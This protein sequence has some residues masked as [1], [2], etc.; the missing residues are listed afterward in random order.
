MRRSLLCA[1]AAC[2]APRLVALW[3]W[4]HPAHTYQWELSESLL[5]HGVFGFDGRSTTYLEPLYPAVLAGL[6]LVAGDRTAIVLLLQIALAAAAGP[7][8]FLLALRIGGRRAAWIA[9]FA[10]ASY[11]YLVRQS[12]AY[13]ALNLTVPLALGAALQMSRARRPAR[14]VSAGVWMGTLM[15]ARASFGLTTVAAAGWVAWRRRPALGALLLASALAIQTPW[16]VRN[17]RVGGVLLPTRVG[18]NLL[19]STSAYA[20]KVV[21][22]YDVDALIPLVYEETAAAVPPDSLDT[23]RAISRA[24]LAR[25]LRF[26]RDHPVRTLRLKLRNAVALL[27]PRLLPR[28]PTGPEARAVLSDG[29]LQLEGL[30]SRPMVQEIGQAAAR[31]TILALVGVAFWERRRWTERD[32]AI[33]LV[34]ATNAILC[35]VFF[36]STRLIVPSTAMLMIYAGVGAVSLRRR[37]E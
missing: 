31:A 19:V 4:P 27:D 30:R 35:V 32:E 9:V 10:Y 6:R 11:P 21:P 12:V 22:I 29:R 8:L 2:V 18:E 13:M 7:L 16:L 3:R 17:V 28:W 15:L 14:A 37:F 36:P 34:A 5:R 20:E 24:M 25:A 23:P 33:L 1:F 26:V